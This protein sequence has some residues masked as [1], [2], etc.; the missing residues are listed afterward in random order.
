MLGIGAY[1]FNNVEPGGTI[2]SIKLTTKPGPVGQA[3]EALRLLTG[4]FD[5]YLKIKTTAA[6]E[7]FKTMTFKDAAI[8]NGLIWPMQRPTKLQELKEVNV[9]D[10]HTIRS[11]KNLDHVVFDGAQW[12]AEGQ[13]FRLDLTGKA[14]E[15][16]KWALPVLSVGA[17]LSALIVLRFI[18][19]Q[20][21]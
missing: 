3:A 17:T 4:T 11:D 16:P 19:D 21:I 18:W 5:L 13:T 9:W 20:V 6:P 1:V 8:G 14:N 10:E 2:E 15:P 12:F 7:P